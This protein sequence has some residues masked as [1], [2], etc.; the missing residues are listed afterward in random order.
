MQILHAIQSLDPARGG[1]PVVAVRLAAAQAGAGHRVGII[2]YSDPSAEA[3]MAAATDRIPHIDQVALHPIAG[4]GRMDQLTASAGRRALRGLLPGID[5]LHLHGVWD[6]LLKAAA[7]EAHAA[8]VPYVVAPHGMLDPWSMA[9][10][11]LKK[12]LALAMGYRSMLNRSSFLHVLNRDE[13]DL[14]APL[15]LRPPCEVLPNGIQP[16]EIQDLP[17]PESFRAEHPAIGQRPYILFLGRVHPKKGLDFLVEAFALVASQHPDI[18]L[19]IAGPDD[20]AADDARA[21]ATRHGIVA[22][23]HLLGPLYGTQK[24]AAY[25]DAACFC[26]P[27]R[28]EGFSMAVLE[29]M[30]C[31][32]PVVISPACHFDE[33]AEQ[34]CGRIVPLD[35]PAIA[36]A[37]REILDSPAL[38]RDMGERARALVLE[39]YTW[40]QIARASIDLYLRYLQPGTGATPLCSFGTMHVHCEETS[41]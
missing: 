32:T 10:K 18:Q 8:G 7:D 12:R 1:P 34:G 36:A 30:A 20:G 6:P 26:L 11:S 5:V 4:G 2:Y 35:P 14:L 13:A 31:R 17:A 27:S 24:L 25:V 3:R 39:R 33:V 9:Q 19:V 37:W 15:R 41:R 40:P 28:Q 21:R 38:A 23:V 16:E 29:A 22:R